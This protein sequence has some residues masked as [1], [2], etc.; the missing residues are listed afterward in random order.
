LSLYAGDRLAQG[1][2]ASLNGADG[3]TADA[4]KGPV[5]VRWRTHVVA[6]PAGER[7]KRC[8]LGMELTGSEPGAAIFP[9][10]TLATRRGTNVAVTL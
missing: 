3:L 7:R 9:E 1:E 2:T 4:R 5:M 10:G 8:A 6:G